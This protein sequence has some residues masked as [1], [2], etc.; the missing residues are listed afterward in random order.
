MH[1]EDEP[2]DFRIEQ[3]DSKI[4]QVFFFSPV[5][6]CGPVRDPIH[7]VRDP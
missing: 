3:V 4:G 2:I 1:P 6:V 5:I 7:L